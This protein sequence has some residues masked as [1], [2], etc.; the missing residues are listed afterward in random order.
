MEDSDAPTVPGTGQQQVG[1]ASLVLGDGAAMDERTA[2]PELLAG[3]RSDSAAS[4]D[5]TELGALRTLA[6]CAASRRRG[7]SGC[8]PG[9]DRSEDVQEERLG[10]R[11]RETLVEN[12][13]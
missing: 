12:G 11:H 10:C 13:A 5:S 1:A 6:R 3:G 7:A 4:S 8:D 2:E 9:G